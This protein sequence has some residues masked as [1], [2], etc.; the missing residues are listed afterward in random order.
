MMLPSHNGAKVLSRNTYEHLE[1]KY[2][3]LSMK[4]HKFFTYLQ[5]SIR[6]GH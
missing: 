4:P 3:V 6:E 5:L 1:Q 2:C